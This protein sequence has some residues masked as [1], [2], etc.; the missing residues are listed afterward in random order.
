MPNGTKRS[1]RRFLQ[2]T[3]GLAVGTA[4]AGCVDDDVDIDEDDDLDLDDDDAD[5]GIDD[6]TDD[7]VPDVDD[8][9]QFV[10]MVNG[11]M[12]TMDSVA[13][14]LAATGTVLNQVYDTLTW[15]PYGELVIENLLAE[16]YEVSD[17]FLTYTFHLKEGVQYHHGFGEMTAD[18]FVYA[19]ERMA[20]SEHTRRSDRIL[21]GFLGIAHETDDDG[22]YVPGSMETEAVDDYTFEFTL[23]APY[24]S[25]LDL[26]PY[27]SFAPIP[28]GLVG[29]ID[30]YDGE[31]EY[32]TFQ[33]E[34]PVGTGAFEF[35]YWE[36]DQECRLD[37]FED[38]HG[39]GPYADGLHFQIMEDSNARYN[40]SMNKNVD[41]IDL[42][43]AHFDPD[44]VD[45][46]ETHEE[47]EREV[48]TYGPMRND[49]TA[50]YMRVAALSTGH[51]TFNCDRVIKEARQATAH[52]LDFD[53]ISTDIYRD[54]TVP[55]YM[56]TPPQIFPGGPEAYWELVE[57]EYP[58]GPGSQIDEA[59]VLMEE[60]GYGE[61]SPYEFTFHITDDST[62]EQMANLMRD[63][64]AAAH[65]DLEIQ[66]TPFATVIDQA[67]EGA[68]DSFNSGWV[69][70]LN[71]PSNIIQ[72]VGDSWDS[73]A[74]NPD[75][76]GLMLN[77]YGT[78]AA[79]QA[80]EA[81]ERAQE[82]GEPTD[83]HEGIRGEAYIEMEK[84]NWE[85]LPYLNYEHRVDERLWYD[86]LDVP[87]FGP[88]SGMKYF[89]A[90]LDERT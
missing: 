38:Y 12:D 88:G 57:E 18:D 90:R 15:E 48:G 68:V 53:Q 51:F 56:F 11:T 21:D 61:D 1:R 70:S 55:G 36:S 10:R 33:N 69:M 66:V 4:I 64:L 35:D 86:W 43:T 6:D 40:Y 20:A 50:N 27:R 47:L 9:E 60:A 23:G 84:A 31:I 32:E 34:L 72:L 65:I 26:L 5:D 24:H 89:E 19:W 83:E 71:E 42:P 58:Y 41:I 30:G 22:N 49:E 81:W 44:L 79:E 28:E 16:E 77:W 37:A 74:D 17:D 76:T 54:R 39:D 67:Y 8:D 80:D 13:S 29:D 7:D 87:L 52:V 25:V 85:E 3:G 46:E 59:R 78:E 2:A 45:I 73:D 82:H 75:A 62:V 14:T 63:Q